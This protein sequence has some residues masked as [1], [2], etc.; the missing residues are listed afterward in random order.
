MHV[1]GNGLPGRKRARC[2]ARLLPMQLA[3]CGVLAAVGVA[4]VRRQRQQRQHHHREEARRGGSDGRRSGASS[5]VL[6][7]QYIVLLNTSLL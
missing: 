3:R 5:L 6:F 2:A 1:L 7:F 4:V